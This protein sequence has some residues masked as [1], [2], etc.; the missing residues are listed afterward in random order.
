[1]SDDKMPNVKDMTNTG[2]LSSALSDFL[3]DL[4][5]KIQKDDDDRAIWKNKMIVAVNQR[6]GI[7]R[8]S[9]WPYPGAPDIPLPET[10][11]LI[12]KQVP[13][14]VLS[15]WSP[16]TLCSVT[17]KTGY[18]ENP[19]W[20]KKA[21]R[22][23][24]AMNSL[25]RSDALDWFKKLY[26]AAD[27]AKQHGHTLFRVREEF[28]SR[29]VSKVVD[30]SEYDDEVVAALKAASKADL[31]KFVAE[32]FGF[33][34]DDDE[35]IKIID[36]IIKQ[37]KD[38][39]ETIEFDYEEI[40]SF[41][42]VDVPL[43]TKVIVP[44]FT[45]DISKSVRIT[46]EYFLSRPEIERLMEKQIFR[47][48]DLTTMSLNGS[49]DDIVEQQKMR[50]E[51]ITENSDTR[52]L[53]RVHECYT[54]FRE[55]ETDQLKR[56]VF[57]FLADCNSPEE[58]LLQDVEFPYEFD[59]WNWEKWDNEIKDERYYS[60]RGLP[61]QIRAYQDILER[62]INNMLIRDE[63][64]NNP[65]WEVQTSSELMDSHIRFI[66]GQ[67]LGVKALGQEIQQLG[68][69]SLPDMASNNIM[70]LIKG[71]VEEYQ[72]SNDYLF[73]N[74]TNAGGGKTL[75]EINV[76]I[77]QNSQP[78][79]LEIISWNETLSRVYQ[80]MFFI[81]KERMG[82]SLWVDGEEITREDFNFPADVKSNGELE[83]ADQ[84]LMTQKAAMRLQAV[85]NPALQDIV[86]SE[87]RYNALK[88]WLEK[89]GVK[90]PDKFCTDPNEVLQGQLQ[91][92][93]QQVQQ[94][95][96]QA[97][98]AQQQAMDAT[99]ETEKQKKTGMQNAAKQ[100]GEREAFM[101]NAGAMNG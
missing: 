9:E 79:N 39:K 22:A 96:A 17:V 80:K 1:M 98:A 32:R 73:R 2:E 43:P 33:D 74:S 27:Y 12:K 83:V 71:Y 16:K 68:T 38:G 44:A 90:D 20:D 81:M 69:Q 5:A 36:S 91:Q 26:R 34:E 59:G 85:L 66:P 88:D 24:L 84:N 13:N 101:Q 19:E 58:S 15:A 51:G 56:W 92:L 41:P 31:S 45:T 30:M 29:I 70:Q 78:L 86:T 61:E 35:D 50:N 49:E 67:K 57:T 60:S 99:K 18:Q 25:L 48:K 54:Y 72:S 42:N 52:E 6:L 46:F 97:G 11:K 8:Y 37:F 14:L 47:K 62:S 4:R 55:K 3:V 95:Q 23:E 40:E 77:Q 64:V 87:D 89:D 76:G 65:M 100:Q 28:R 82:D 53:F 10:D 7:K 63:M 94:L 21:K 93:Q 75:G